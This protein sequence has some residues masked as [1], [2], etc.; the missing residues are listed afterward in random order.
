MVLNGVKSN[1]NAPLYKDCKRAVLVVF[2]VSLKI[3]ILKHVN[4]V[5]KAV[6]CTSD[7][8]ICIIKEGNKH[9][10]SRSSF[11]WVLKIVYMRE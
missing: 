5:F 6:Y 9:E 11:L 2:I 4:G 1:G 7:G 8:L 10:E 3:H